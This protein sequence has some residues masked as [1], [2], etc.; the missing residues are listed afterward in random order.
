M[1]KIIVA[2]DGVSG[3]GKSSTARAVAQQL[4]Y[5]YIDTGAMYRAVALFFLR[6]QIDS[7][8]P[9]QVQSE[10]DRISLDFKFNHKVG[11]NEILLN[12]ISVEDHIRSMEVNETVSDISALPAV[13]KALRTRQQELGKD[14]GVVMDGRDIG[15]AIFPKAEL[16]VFF[17][18]DVEVR[19]RR[20]RLDFVRD[21]DQ[22]SLEQIEENLKERDHKDIRRNSSPLTKASD[23]YEID[24][25]NITLQEQI[26][27]VLELAR[28]RIIETE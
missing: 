7:P 6:E 3:S 24:T 16:K 18:A 14:K 12:G 15:T 11:R 5:S 20:R 22:V 9:E 21:G 19:S 13:R 4:G 2:I 17:T 1:G 23:A 28:K 8:S 26:Q 10:M 25:S 27:Q